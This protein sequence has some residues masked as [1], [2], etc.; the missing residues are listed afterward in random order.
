LFDFSVVVVD[1]EKKPEA[2][3]VFAPIAVL[4]AVAIPVVYPR[5]VA[6]KLVDCLRVMGKGLF[7]HKE[8]AFGLRGEVVTV[9]VTSFGDKQPE[10]ESITHR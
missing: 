9:C 6:L 5:S 1:V 7:T 2:K 8:G 10:I 3:L 4:Q